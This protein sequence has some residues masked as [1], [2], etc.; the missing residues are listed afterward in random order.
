MYDRNSSSKMVDGVRLDMFAFK[1]RSYDSIPPTHAATHA[2]KRV[3]Y[4]GDYI[5]GQS[6]VCDPY[7]PNPSSWGCH[8]VKGSW[9]PYWTTLPAIA[10]SCQ[11]LTKFRCK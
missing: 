6:R 4:Q 10:T 11:E 9:Q 3:A 1:Q 2:T 5:W 8:Q 7:I